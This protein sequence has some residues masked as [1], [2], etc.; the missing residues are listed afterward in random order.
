MSSVLETQQ[1]RIKRNDEKIRAKNAHIQHFVLDIHQCI[2]SKTPKEYPDELI[3]LY[4]R[5]V[6]S[7]DQ[8][9]VVDPK[10]IEGMV[11]QVPP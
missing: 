1:Q 11:R 4:K 8:I 2:S 6:L 3:T 7:S 9:S 10:G 5:Y